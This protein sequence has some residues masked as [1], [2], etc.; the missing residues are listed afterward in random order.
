V[1][2]ARYFVAR[3]P[4]SRCGRV[5]LRRKV[6]W[7]SCDDEGP[8]ERECR[9]GGCEFE[10]ELVEDLEL[11]RESSDARR[12]GVCGSVKSESLFGCVFRYRIRENVDDDVSNIAGKSGILG[13][14]FLGV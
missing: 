6:L 11:R 2:G 10:V 13:L 7:F 9:R 1:V 14:T 3:F 8:E 12:R 5:S 4:R